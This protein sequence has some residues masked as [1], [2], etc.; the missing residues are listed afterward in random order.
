[1]Y[2][3]D[4]DKSGANAY[5]YVVDDF[6]FNEGDKTGG[7][8]F[9]SGTYT[10]KQFNGYF[11]NIAN[12]IVDDGSLV[13]HQTI[14]LSAGDN[15]TDAGHNAK[16]VRDWV[17]ERLAADNRLDAANDYLV[18]TFEMKM[19][20]FMSGSENSVGFLPDKIYVTAVIEWNGSAFAQKGII[21]N[22]MNAQTYD[23][24]L[25]LMHL[26][27]DASNPDKVNI[28]TIVGSSINGPNLLKTAKNISFGTCAG[29]G[30]GNVTVADR[31]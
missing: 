26:E 24:L 27:P 25:E 14:V 5:N 9:E 28:D 16:A 22:A 30:I 8:T 12:R 17:N 1:M 3:Y 4:A 19:D 18:V 20:D 7:G 29:D 11:V 23:V 2:V 21:F 13:A 6:M 10:D 31:I 15:R